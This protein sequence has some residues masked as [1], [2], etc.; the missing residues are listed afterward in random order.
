[1][2]VIHHPLKSAQLLKASIRPEA[3]ILCHAVSCFTG[4]GFRVDFYPKPSPPAA[5]QQMPSAGCS[6]CRCRIAWSL[7]VALP[8]PQVA[9]ALCGRC[10]TLRRAVVAK[11]SFATSGWGPHGSKTLLLCPG[12]RSGVQKISRMHSGLLWGWGRNAVFREKSMRGSALCCQIG[13]C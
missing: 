3:A 2:T 11:P 4:L 8:P 13:P 12:L 1:M 9:M 5:S 6:P 10:A 7:A